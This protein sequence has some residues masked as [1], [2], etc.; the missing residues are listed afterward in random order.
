MASVKKMTRQELL[1]VLDSVK[2]KMHDAIRSN[3]DIEFCELYM[4]YKS[5]NERLIDLDYGY[6]E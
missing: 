4:E 6:I 5:I 1:K 2:E 3:E